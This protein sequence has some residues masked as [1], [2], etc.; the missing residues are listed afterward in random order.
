MD[1]SAYEVYDHASPLLKN[2]RRQILSCQ[3]EIS[4]Q[5][6]KFI[7]ANASKLMDTITTT[8]NDRIC[9]LAKISEK[10]SI[11]GYVH[12]EIRHG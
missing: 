4:S 2:L 6:Q 5:T 8:R 11:R 7:Q 9:V 3:G 1:Y 12:G 10:N